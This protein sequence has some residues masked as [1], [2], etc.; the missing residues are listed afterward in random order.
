[1]G[2]KRFGRTVVA[3][4]FAAILVGGVTTDRSGVAGAQGEVDP[5]SARTQAALV[6]VG[7][8]RGAL[9]LSPQIGLVLTDFLGT[10]GRGDVRTAD[11]AALAD[12]LPK[13]LIDA[14][15]ALKV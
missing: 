5:G 13:E 15:P 12:S 10:R 9:S 8:S 3:V 2:S 1:M 4:V 11:F 6:R 7:P 14:P